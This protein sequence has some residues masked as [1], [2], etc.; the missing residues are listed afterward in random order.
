MHASRVVLLTA[1][2][3]KTAA[4]QARATRKVGVVLTAHVQ[5]AVMRFAASPKLQAMFAM[6]R[7]QVL[8]LPALAFVFDLAVGLAGAAFGVI[9]ASVAFRMARA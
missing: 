4:V 9:V 5:N 6:Q 7:D 3:T 2:S 8:A 1:L